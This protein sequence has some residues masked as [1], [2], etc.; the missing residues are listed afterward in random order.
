MSDGGAYLGFCGK[1][2]IEE[3]GEG[4]DKGGVG[5][6]NVR[7][8]EGSR[9]GN[10]L[11]DYVMSKHAVIA[12]VR[13][14]SQQLGQHGI[15][16]NSVSPFGVATPLTCAMLGKEEEE[17]EKEYE[18]CTPLKGIVLKVKHVADAVLFL[19]SDES[20]FISGHDM[21][22]DGGFLA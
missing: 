2:K 16:V 18:G 7:A 15:R 19:V 3:E 10:K 21:V 6:D 5:G 9:G 13:S 1:K 11:T 17:V 22:I 14:A 12:L 8:K 20:G 4:G